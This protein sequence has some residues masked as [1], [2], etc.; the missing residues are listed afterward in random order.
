MRKGIAESKA[1]TIPLTRSALKKMEDA[2]FK[3]FQVKGLTSDKHYDY[4]DPHFL[5]L[6]PMKELPTDQDKKDIYEP[7]KSDLLMKWAMDENSGLE[8]VIASQSL[9][10]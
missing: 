4:I 7:V 6:V 5:V 2:G 9:S 3:Y 10:N 8:V 1:A